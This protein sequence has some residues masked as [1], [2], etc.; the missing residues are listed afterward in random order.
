MSFRLFRV[1]KA[2]KAQAVLPPNNKRPPLPLIHA[3]ILPD[4]YERPINIIAYMDT[5]AA[6]TIMKP[7]ILLLEYWEPNHTYFYAANGNTFSVC[8]I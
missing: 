3:F 1:E 4:K 7:S 8:L 2:L 6:K 5:G